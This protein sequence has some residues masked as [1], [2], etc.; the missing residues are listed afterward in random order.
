VTDAS[1]TV[2]QRELGLRLRKIRTGLG[3]T[4]EDV[5][6]KLM[7]SPA[8]V[9][10]LETGAR[11][12]ALRDVR[13][14]CSIY[15][16][17]E[18]ASDELMGLAR[19]AREPIWWTKYDEIELVPYI[20]LEQDASSITA[21]SLYYL[22]ALLQT[23]D[24]ARAL[25][26]AINPKIGQG[27]LEQ[28]VRTRLRRQQRLEGDNPPRYRALIDEAIFHRKVGNDALMTAQVDKVLNLAEAGKVVVQLIPFDRGVYPAADI[29]F[30]LLEF[31]QLPPIVF[32]EGL[33]ESQHFDRPDQIERYREAIESVRDSAL[34]PQDSLHRLAE[35][36]KGYDARSGILLP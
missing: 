13:E 33:A 16:L 25:I 15:S 7:C 11:R 28:R 34:G 3:L 14:L 31:A 26:R 5:A 10:R 35:I 18:K 17:D 2:R 24:Y 20:G 6:R 12:P 23:E 30:V 21:Y 29:M 27:T 19:Q 22:P 1:P 4:V 9:S 36:R 32:V 8:K